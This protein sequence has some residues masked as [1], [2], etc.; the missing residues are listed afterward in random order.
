MQALKK[1]DLVALLA[2]AG[3]ITDEIPVLAAEQWLASVGLKAIRGSH[4]LGRKGVFSGTDR[5]RLFDLQEAIDNPEVKAIWAVRGGYG[6]MRIMSQLNFKKLKEQPKWLIGFSDITAFHNQW[7]LLG[8]PSIHGMMPVQFAKSPNDTVA[9]LEGLR[10]ALM[11]EKL[12]YVLAP[13]KHNKMGTA[14]GV[15]TGGNLTLL[16]SL[17]G[18]PYQVDTKGKILFIEDV[19][20]YVYRIDRLLYSMKLAGAFEHLKG[21]I[22]GG[23]TDMKENDTPFDKSIPQ[24]ILDVTKGKKY[25]IL[26]DFPAGHFPDNQALILGQKVQM[27]I[28][29]KQSQITFPQLL[30]DFP[31]KAGTNF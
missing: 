20:E 24:M 17:M 27:K 7:Q 12:E 30:T 29:P 6:A 21:L 23:F 25:P 3:F 8:L 19:G 10:K 1:N 5:E 13:N 28:T 18:T 2:P 15:L 31:A 16:Q 11:G 14:E 26:F 9:G 22:V 4:V